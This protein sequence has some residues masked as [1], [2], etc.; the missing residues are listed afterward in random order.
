MVVY[1]QSNKPSAKFFYFSLFAPQPK[2]LFTRHAKIQARHRNHGI[3]TRSMRYTL[4]LMEYLV[5]R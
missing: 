3:P 2:Y 1:L 4:P 5:H